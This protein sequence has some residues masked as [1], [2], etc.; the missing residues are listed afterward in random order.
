MPPMIEF[1][2]IKEPEGSGSGGPVDDM[3]ISNL[4]DFQSACNAL[5]AF[6]EHIK[7]EIEFYDVREYNPD[8]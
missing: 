1:R 6:F 3:L 2:A 8:L 4:L 5:L 7:S